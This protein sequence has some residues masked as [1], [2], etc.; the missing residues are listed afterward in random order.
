MVIFEKNV[1]I[2]KHRNI[3]RQTSM[4]LFESSVRKTKWLADQI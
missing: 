4:E 3:L 2:D 1:N